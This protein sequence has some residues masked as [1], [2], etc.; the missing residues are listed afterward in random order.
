MDN[1]EMEQSITQLQVLL[2]MLSYATLSYEQTKDI[3]D[4]LDRYEDIFYLKGYR[5]LE[6][7]ENE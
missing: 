2:D 5:M 3:E 7:N 4:L 1:D 6:E